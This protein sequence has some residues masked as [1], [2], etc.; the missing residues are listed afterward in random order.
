MA[1]DDMT[2]PREEE[3]KRRGLI[4]SIVLHLALI[5]LALLPLLTFPDPP[6]GQEGILVNLGL[7]DEGQGFD[8]APPA[9]PAAEVAPPEPD[10]VR[11]EP[12]VEPQPRQPEPVRE[13]E[14]VRTEDPE[15]VALKRRQEQE[16]KLREEE[17]RKQRQ[18]EEAQ[19]RAEAER[20]RREEA[21]ARQR[22]EAE[23]RR[24]EEANKLRDQIGGLFGGGQGKGNTGKPGNQGDPSGDPSSSQLEGLS[25]GA[26]RVGGGLS[27][28]GVLSLPKPDETS[29][30]TGTVVIEVCVDAN[31][32]VSDASYTQRGST[33]A[34]VDL[35]RSAIAAARKA[36][37]A[38]GEVDRQCGTITYNFRL[39]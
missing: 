24:Q 7:P 8:N 36:K 14:V 39:R 25:T 16:R 11:E 35:V 37:F 19:R 17:L 30:N 29:Q 1:L 6:P 2:T 3:H 21:E 15:A 10:P 12:R 32:N 23:A 20:R 27:N 34:N 33:T 5:L 28:R 13:R 31:G 22:A 4:L 18:E 9:A 26:G 38:K